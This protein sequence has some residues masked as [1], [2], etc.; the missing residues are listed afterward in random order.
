MEKTEDVNAIEKL[1]NFIDDSELKK[2]V[3]EAVTSKRFQEYIGNKVNKKNLERCVAEHNNSGRKIFK[4][5]PPPVTALSGPALAQEIRRIPG[6]LLPTP[7]LAFALHHYFTL[8]HADLLRECLSCLGLS[9]DS[10]GNPYPFSVVEEQY[11]TESAL[12]NLAKSLAENYG[13]DL[14]KKYFAAASFADKSLSF[15]EDA[16]SFVPEVAVAGLA[17]TKNIK[18]KI[19]QGEEIAPTQPNSQSCAQFKSDEFINDPLW[20]ASIALAE[21]LKRFVSE[22][23]QGILSD[24]TAAIDDWVQL[25]TSFKSLRN[26]EGLPESM[27]IPELR[28][29]GFERQRR[30]DIELLEQV[31]Q[32]K[33]IGTGGKNEVGEIAL[34]AERYASEI[35][36][37]RDDGV[38]PNVLR[39]FRRIVAFIQ[40]RQMNGLALDFA[41]LSDL[42]TSIAAVFGTIPALAIVAGHAT[43]DGGGEDAKSD[44]H[45]AV[46]TPASLSG[47]ESS[48]NQRE[49][50]EIDFSGESEVSDIEAAGTPET[51][52]TS[53]DGPPQELVVSTTEE[54]PDLSQKITVS[55]SVAPKRESEATPVSFPEAKTAENTVSGYLETDSAGYEAFRAKHW[56]NAEGLVEEAPW[57]RRSDFVA[58]LNCTAQRTLSANSLTTAFLTQRAVEELGEVPVIPS[59]LLSDAADILNGEPVNSPS[60]NRLDIFESGGCRAHAATCKLSLVIE[61][62][63]PAHDIWAYRERVSAALNHAQFANPTLSRMVGALINDA[64]EGAGVRILARRQVAVALRSAGLAD[65]SLTKFASDLKD[66]FE[67]L[68]TVSRRLRTELCRNA[69]RAFLRSGAE[70]SIRTIIKTDSSELSQHGIAAAEQQVRQD[71]LRCFDDA[72]AKFEDRTRM[73]RAVQ[74]IQQKLVALRQ[75]VED[76]QVREGGA[77]LL[78]RFDFPTVT[79]IQALASSDPCE[80]IE[81]LCRDLLFSLSAS[82]ART[83][84][85]LLVAE[86]LIKWPAL[87]L[88][89]GFNR[90]VRIQDFEFD[91]REVTFPIEASAVL[92]TKPFAVPEESD[93]VQTIKEHIFAVRRLD[94]MSMYLAEQSLNTA[95]R[96]RLQRQ[97]RAEG[98]DRADEM[99]RK[100]SEAW[101]ECEAVGAPISAGMS[102]HL[103]EARTLLDQAEDATFPHTLMLTAWISHLRKVCERQTEL[104]A[105]AIRDKIALRY[106]DLLSQVDEAIEKKRFWE[107][108]IALDGVVSS[109]GQSPS[110]QGSR[111]TPWREKTDATNTRGR[112]QL[113]T[114]S[115]TLSGELASF[116][117][118]WLSDIDS[119]ESRRALRRKF[120]DFATGDMSPISKPQRRTRKDSLFEREIKQKRIV[121]D[122]GSVLSM[123]EDQGVNPSFIPQFHSF[124]SIV[125]LSAPKSAVSGASGA[126]VLAR[127]IHSEV[128]SDTQLGSSV[129]AVVLVPGISAAMR[130]QVMDEFQRRQNAFVGV[131]IDDL[132]VLRMFAEQGAPPADIRRFLEIVAE[133]FSLANA[134]STPYSS[135]DG[136][137]IRKEMYVGR[138]G[139]AEAL[140]LTS[141]YSR[142]FSGRKLGKSAFLKSVADKYNDRS[143]PSGNRLSVLFVSIAGGDSDSY[144]CD[145]I[146]RELSAR[147][148]V[149]TA[150]TFINDTPADKLLRAVEYVIRQDPK[151]S[152]LLLLDEADAFVEDQLRQYDREREKCLSFRLMKEVTQHIDSAGLPR[153]RVIFSGYRITNTRDGAWANAGEVLILPP[154]AQ[155]E[156]NNLIVAPL[157]R[158]GIDAQAQAD[159]ISRRCG[160]QPAII[161]KVG[162]TL[163]KHLRDNSPLTRKEVLRLSNAHVVTAFNDPGIAD[164]I[165][166]VMF[167]NF[168][169]NPVGQI[170]FAAMLLAFSRLA[171]GFELPD[172]E[173]AVLSQ[174]RAIDPHLDWLER[175]DPSLTGEIERQLND[176]QDRRLVRRSD[177]KGNVYYRLQVSHSLPILLAGDLPGQ[178]KRAIYIL[179]G[180]HGFEMQP[181]RGVLSDAQL[182][183]IKNV[184]GIQGR[185]PL[186]VVTGGWPTA[187]ND[188]R[189]GVADRIGISPSDMCTGNAGSLLENARAVVNADAALIESFIGRTRT[190][191][192]ATGGVDVARR[193]LLL[194]KEGADVYWQPLSRVSAFGV[195]WWFERVRSFHFASP[196]SVEKII[197]VTG[198]I[199]LLLEIV[200]AMLT[201]QFEEDADISK[202]KFAELELRLPSVIGESARRLSLGAVHERLEKREVEVLK[203]LCIMARALG[204]ISL[205]DEFNEEYWVLATDGTSP[206]LLPPSSEDSRVIELLTKTGLVKSEDGTMIYDANSPDPIFAI[207]DAL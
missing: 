29:A 5:L 117:E 11:R 136:Q 147:F 113:R 13:S 172:A 6:K 171:P 115:A 193:M 167:N 9:S 59:R 185:P 26:S 57:V 42:Q 86:D 128:H 85:M 63:V 48:Q 7:F 51:L 137:H 201:R 32:L 104:S 34:K 15:M 87:A 129:V 158:L 195:R 21:Q 186:I 76:Q 71:A 69:W 105:T 142:V 72:G 23:E 94:V 144:I 135:Q 161:N 81:E 169:G 130:H 165:R 91:A 174:I 35:K 196:E 47:N 180:V 173:N 28:A 155:E 178:I 163:L 152:I 146:I 149:S 183:A 143:L 19:L 64:A 125:I 53:Q 31:A 84:P 119:E 166:T 65:V 109:T 133:Q 188:R 176:F 89:L 191:S 111:W 36:G 200:D 160:N 110:I 56:I 187:L 40:T 179:R 138:A 154:L 14:V 95:E 61:A 182:D 123:L 170:V 93:V 1:Q 97:L 100:L 118:A 3:S 134:K 74:D 102:S 141:K 164:E 27:S 25:F 206:E 112:D 181:V 194:D 66:A 139:D 145:R 131:V 88:H 77:E 114:V 192:L 190:V 82:T 79:E 98:V 45:Q 62:L 80:P 162:D 132:D 106:P 49:E 103:I 41:E 54:Q 10:A 43:I 58:D 199:P 203:M 68:T 156:A 67:S 124:S 24:P 140:A 16:I 189:V 101:F 177:T 175:R 204:R 168:Q 197:T 153:V 90:P 99:F 198:C 55:E 50:P 157:A 8:H 4:N 37:Q 202:A 30:S 75:A 92:L 127:W 12:K 159:F 150:G 148:A 122:S 52:A 38:D 73:D 39:I 184:L 96:S 22:L 126:A 120:F 205:E 116:L 207:A 17:S 33:A 70:S 60:R 18:N 20:C 2:I 151:V 83:D 107:L 44:A 46:M 121:I 108:P 78:L